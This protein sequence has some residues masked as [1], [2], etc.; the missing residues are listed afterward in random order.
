MDVYCDGEGDRLKANHS[1]F[2]GLSLSSRCSFANT[3][4]LTFI[5]PSSCTYTKKVCLLLSD[6][7]IQF[8][9]ICIFV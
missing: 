9:F 7:C 2:S 6:D 4:R 3:A 8:D 1:M 5:E